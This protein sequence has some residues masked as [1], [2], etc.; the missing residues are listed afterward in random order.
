MLSVNNWKEKKK[1][2]NLVK[3]QN[4]WNSSIRSSHPYV[5]CKKGV[6]ENF[7]KFVGK[8]LSQSLL[9]NKVA[10]LRS[11]TLIK[12]RLWHRCFPVNF[13]KVL[14]T[15]LFTEHLWWLLLLIMQN[16]IKTWEQPGHRKIAEDLTF[17][18]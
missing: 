14:R 17:M 4:C 6:L 10:G 8:H 11:G 12:T 16:K 13:A 5:F 1:D 2:F 15:S 3:N 18:T 7:A 9:F